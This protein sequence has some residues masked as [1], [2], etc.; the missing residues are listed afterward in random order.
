MN[1]KELMDMESEVHTLDSDDMTSKEQVI[2]LSKQ[3]SRT[4]V[5]VRR[6]QADKN[7]YRDLYTT[8]ITQ[9][10]K[11]KVALD[12]IIILLDDLRRSEI[13]DFPI[14]VRGIIEE[15]LKGDDIPE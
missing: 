4:I 3:L 7:T 6:L 12:E 14:L 1:E 2:Y 15:A 8:Q 5:E 9:I 13:H 10:M 11:Y